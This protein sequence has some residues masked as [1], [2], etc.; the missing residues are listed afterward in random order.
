MTINTA[1][2]SV[3]FYDYERKAKIDLFQF[4]KWKG[5]MK[6]GEFEIKQLKLCDRKRHAYEIKQRPNTH[7]RG[8]P[9]K[10]SLTRSRNLD[11]RSAE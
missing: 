4:L 9:K 10:A 8:R 2:V 11:K 7:L 5:K 3:R 1:D 6:T